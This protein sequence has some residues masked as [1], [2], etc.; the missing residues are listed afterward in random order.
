MAHTENGTFDVSKYTVNM[1]AYYKKVFKI[2]TS[3]I[4]M[5]NNNLQTQNHC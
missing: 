5:F 2:Y 4:S 3:H 1:Y